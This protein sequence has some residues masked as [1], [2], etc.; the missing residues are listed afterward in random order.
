MTE[1][2]TPPSE[3][4]SASH[5]RLAELIGGYQ[6]SAAIGAFAR[7]GVAD[8]LADGPATS[9]ALAASVG[10]DAG[11]LARLL[12]ATLATGLLTLGGDGRYCLT[13]LGDLLRTDVPGSL[14]RYAAT[15]PSLPTRG[16]GT[17]TDTSPT[18]CKPASPG[19]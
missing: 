15:Q 1:G 18:R 7:L 6:V 19:S 9:A 5:R 4:S 8:A 3:Q 17:P 11:A 2:A 14:R 16:A 10:A 12:D 13:A